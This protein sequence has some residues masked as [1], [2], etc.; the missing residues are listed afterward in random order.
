MTTGFTASNRIIS[1]YYLFEIMGS[2]LEV[3][4]WYEMNRSNL[5]CLR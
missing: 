2:T 4:A 1:Q 3:C 5:N